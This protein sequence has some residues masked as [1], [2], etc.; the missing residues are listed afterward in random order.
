MYLHYKSTCRA[1]SVLCSRNQLHHTDFRVRTLCELVLYQHHYLQPSIIS[2]MDPDGMVVSKN[3]LIATS[4]NLSKASSECMIDVDFATA[5][6]Q[7]DCLGTAKDGTFSNM[8]HLHGLASVLESSVTSIYLEVKSRIRPLLHRVVHPRQ[9]GATS[10]NV[11]FVIM[12]TSTTETK[13]TS[14]WSPSHFVSCYDKQI[15][16]SNVSRAN[17]SSLMSSGGANIADKDPSVQNQLKT[18]HCLPHQLI[19]S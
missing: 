13:V 9:Q 3:A 12:W 18:K 15:L 16:S 11:P 19:P 10:E 7:L 6:L 8:I 14:E 4:E 17:I 5:V 2:L 1:A